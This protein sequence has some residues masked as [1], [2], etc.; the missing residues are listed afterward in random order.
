MTPQDV[1]LATL[2][3]LQLQLHHSTYDTWLRDSKFVA[4]DEATH[5]YTI[6]VRNTYAKDWLEQKLYR[7][8]Q[9]GLSKTAHDEA[10]KICFVSNQVDVVEEVGEDVPPE[11]DSVAYWRQRALEAEQRVA[12]LEQQIETEADHARRWPTPLQA[13]NGSRRQL[14]IDQDELQAALPM[15]R[16]HNQ[17]LALLATLALADQHT[18]Q[19]ETTAG[20]MGRLLGYGEKRRQWSDFMKDLDNGK[21]AVGE[22]IGHTRRVTL[23]QIFVPILVTN[24]PAVTENV[25]NFVTNSVTPPPSMPT[26]MSQILGQIAPLY[27]YYVLLQIIPLFPL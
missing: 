8:V 16:E 4:Y 12:Q 27:T 10:V 25:T 21:I 2:S 26:E 20:E 18:G 15:I 17:A 19:F 6:R 3:Q 22:Q 13:V 14:L 1:W 9:Q 7:A 5:T 11:M 24:E 23:K